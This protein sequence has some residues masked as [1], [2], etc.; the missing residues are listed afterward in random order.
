MGI[1]L[2]KSE[3]NSGVQQRAAI[4]EQRAAF[5]LYLLIK[6]QASEAKTHYSYYCTHHHSRP[7]VEDMDQDQFSFWGHTTYRTKM[8]QTLFHRK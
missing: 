6:K 8:V 3:N 4:S 5:F 1:S 2:I 7:G